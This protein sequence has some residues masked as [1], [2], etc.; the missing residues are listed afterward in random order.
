MEK[1]KRV[2]WAIVKSPYLP[3]AIF[4]IIVAALHISMPNNFADDAWFYRILEGREDTLN[5]WKEFLVW[6]YNSWSSRTAIEGLL[7]VLVRKPLLWKILD[8]VSII[9]VVFT[10]SDL[11]NFERSRTKNI[12]IALV[13]L[14]FPE[15]LYEVGYVA[16]SLNY[17]IPFAAALCAIS[18]MYKRFSLRDV[19]KF[20]YVIALLLLLFAC[21]SEILSATVLLIAL[22]SGAW[23]VAKNKRV[24]AFEVACLVISIAFLI[25]HLTC[26][27]NDVRYVQESATWLPEHPSLNLF[28]K[29]EL[30]FSSMMQTL[31][32]AKNNFVG[33]FCLGIA[34]A[35]TL[36]SRKAHHLIFA[37]IPFV[38][39]TI[40]STLYSIF[41]KIRPLAALKNHMLA[42]CGHPSITFNAVITDIVFIFILFCILFTLRVIIKDTRD[43]IA[44][45]FILG[46]GAAS[47]MSLGLSPTVWSSG[48]RATTFLYVALGVVTV[49]AI[50]YVFTDVVKIA[51]DRYLSKKSEGAQN[52]AQ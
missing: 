8:T 47:R 24:P 45:F 31:F 15:V 52:T 25:F 13:A 34:L 44:V 39:S 2:A 48:G 19:S 10:I 3:L 36:K 18:V 33:V 12:I 20:E 46:V 1:L 14:I 6:R 16:T 28:E 5:A 32:L 9:Y 22:G 27:G 4:A 42:A 50:N 17:I 7:I 21:F 37:W 26:V 41:I 11:I 43:Y 51:K 35:L 38:F 30:G 49:I 23:Y 29:V 40:F